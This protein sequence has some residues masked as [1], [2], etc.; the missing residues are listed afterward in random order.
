M[1]CS[2]GMYVSKYASL[3]WTAGVACWLLFFFFFSKPCPGYV[4]MYICFALFLVRP[5]TSRSTPRPVT[6]G[7]MA[8]SCTRSG[9][10]DTNRSR[11]AQTM[12]YALVSCCCCCSFLPHFQLFS[13]EGSF[14]CDESLCLLCLIGTQ[15][16]LDCILC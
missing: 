7:A 15:D 4:H 13:S 8:W 1:D 5:S 6:C 9:A 16:F 12:R 2:R 11:S 14:Q 10:W 3:Y